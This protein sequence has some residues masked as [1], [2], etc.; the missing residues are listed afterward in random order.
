M[1]L[2]FFESLSKTDEFAS[3]RR[4]YKSLVV[5]S[6]FLGAVLAEMEAC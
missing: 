4:V 6:K 2:F 1:Y 3:L 5:S